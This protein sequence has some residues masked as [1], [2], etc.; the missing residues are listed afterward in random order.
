VDAGGGKAGPRAA[1]ARLALKALVTDRIDAWRTGRATARWYHDMYREPNRLGW[2]RTQ[3]YIVEMNRRTLDQG[4]RFLVASWPLMVHLE[5]DDPFADI[6][7]DDRPFLPRGG[8][9]PP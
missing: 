9:P 3:G 2:Q 6:S 8:H 7:P 5:G 1:P 4:G